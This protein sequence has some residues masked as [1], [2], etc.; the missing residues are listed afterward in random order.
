[1][2]SITAAKEKGPPWFWGFRKDSSAAASQL[3]ALKEE[4][5]CANNITKLECQTW[6][7]SVKI[8]WFDPWEIATGPG[9][10]G[11]TCWERTPEASPVLVLYS[12]R[13]I[14]LWFGF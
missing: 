4:I 1:M 13:A 3:A 12:H 2:F 8:P 10:T 11:N 6:E 7:F 14:L 9:N 5:G